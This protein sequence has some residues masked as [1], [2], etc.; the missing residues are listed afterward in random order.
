MD[1]VTDNVIAFQN[2]RDSDYYLIVK[3]YYDNFKKW[4]YNQVSDFIDWETFNTD[5]DYKLYR[6]VDT[7][8]YEKATYLAEKHGW[9]QSGVFNRLFYAILSNWR[10]NIKSS[11][12][13]PRKRP[14]V[15]CPICGRRVVRIDEEH[16]QHYKSQKDLPRAFSWENTI[17]RTCVRVGLN[18]T[19]WGKYAPRKL[20]AINNG[21]ARK[22]VSHKQTVEWPWFSDQGDRMV[23]CPFTKRLIP[24]INLAYIRSLPDR[25]SR[26]AS[27]VS[28]QSFAEEYPNILIQCDVYSLDFDHDNS[29]KRTRVTL[30]DTVQRDCRL[31][32]TQLFSDSNDFESP[33]AR[34]LFD[35]V[36]SLIE[37]H[38]SDPTNQRIL[39]LSAAG[40][41]ITNIADEMKMP[42]QD[43]RKRIKDI[44]TNNQDLANE[45]LRL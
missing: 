26:Y 45:L 33:R 44:R 13:R 4:W 25:Y 34:L 32:T 42:R 37:Q 29:D 18:A 23:C 35:D 28:W 1:V 10:F 5:F 11:A 31:G 17:Y 2:T 43:V 8:D 41:D 14:T 40:Y 20:H 24:I 38:I 3:R 39:K 21:K 36:F 9:S 19:T 27:P 22:Y 6:A 16:L 12:F 7:F 30:R 15:E